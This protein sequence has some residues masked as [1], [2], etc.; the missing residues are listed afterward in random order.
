MPKS[1]YPPEHEEEQAKQEALRVLAE[2]PDMEITTPYNSGLEEDVEV[3]VYCNR[4]H[5]MVMYFMLA[6]LNALMWICFAPIAD[7]SA[8]L[9][10]TT[11]NNVNWLSLSFLVSYTPGACCQLIV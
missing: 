5:I 2:K 11:T 8:S 1:V 10:N 9:F 7:Y 3:R 6:M 4:W